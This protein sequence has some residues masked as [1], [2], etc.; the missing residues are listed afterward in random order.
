MMSIASFPA[1]CI[2][3][4]SMNSNILGWTQNVWARIQSSAAGK[5]SFSS[6][7]SRLLN[8]SASS[9]SKNSSMEG[10]PD[11]SQDLVALGSLRC[12]TAWPTFRD[13]N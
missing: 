8:S 6:S 11:S 7:G 1:L 9:H 2:P 5:L 13:L 12:F 4:E 3:L 10:I